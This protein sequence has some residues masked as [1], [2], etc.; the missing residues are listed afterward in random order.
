MVYRVPEWKGWSD[1]MEAFKIIKNRYGEG[2]ELVV[3][4]FTQPPNLDFPFT[5]FQ[6]PS[7]K[8]LPQIY[9]SCDVFVYTSHIE[10]LGKPPLEAM[11]CKVAVVTTDNLGCREYAEDGRTALVV[12][13]RNPER[14]AEAVVKLLENESLRKKIAM[15]GYQMVQQKFT[16]KKEIDALEE[17]FYKAANGYLKKPPAKWNNWEKVLLVSPGDAWAHYNLGL[18]RY[19]EGKAE[20]AKWEFEEAIRLNPN[21]PNPYKSLS[22]LYMNCGD[23]TKAQEKLRKWHQLSKKKLKLPPIVEEMLLVEDEKEEIFNI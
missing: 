14:I 2:V 21:F 7:L 16:W 19:R 23:I 12:P 4:G 11:A 1:G 15:E 20:E 5:Y 17:L 13:I 22:E 8:L 10:G 6:N 9:S 18:L 3:F